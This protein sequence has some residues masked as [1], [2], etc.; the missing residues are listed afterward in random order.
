MYGP[1]PPEE[2]YRRNFALVENRIWE[3]AE[4]L[5]AKG[6]DV[7]LD[8]GFWSR[9]SRDLAR[10][11]AL[12]A[13]AV[14]R[15]YNVSC[16]RQVA[17]DRTLERSSNPPPESLWIDLPAFEKLDALFEPMEDDEEYLTVPGTS[18]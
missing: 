10:D 16:P 1:C 5:V 6:T 13:G 3:Q 17:L 7:I 9:E 15:F 4:A 12:A 11:R 2:P 14:P 18:A 8:F